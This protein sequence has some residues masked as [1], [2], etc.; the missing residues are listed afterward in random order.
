MVDLCDQ[1]TTQCHMSTRSNHFAGSKQIK[2][3][4]YDAT[5]S[6]LNDTLVTAGVTHCDHHR[7]HTLP[8]SPPFPTAL[9]KQR[10]TEATPRVRFQNIHNS[11]FGRIMK[12]N[13]SCIVLQPNSDLGVDLA[14]ESTQ[15]FFDVYDTLVSTYTESG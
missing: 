12:H 3:I 2:W 6:D 4:T 5:T 13:R 14:S 10:F 8:I 1:L 9:R 15:C 11:A 7:T